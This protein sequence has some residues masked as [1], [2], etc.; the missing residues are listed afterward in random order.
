MSQITINA[1]IACFCWLVNVAGSHLPSWA[2]QPQKV[3]LAQGAATTVH[4][5]LEEDLAAHSGAY[6]SNCKI[7]KPH[8]AALDTA[9]AVKLW[10]TTEKQLAGC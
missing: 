1:G 7:K 8:K 4:A 10:D 5:A 9:L 6:L 3:M 2:A